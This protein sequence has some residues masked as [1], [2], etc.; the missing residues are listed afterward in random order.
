MI[1]RIEQLWNVKAT[2]IQIYIIQD[3]ID[4][5]NLQRLDK[6]IREEEEGM[7]SKAD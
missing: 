3:E 5:G 6:N 1:F 2:N 4:H 7:K